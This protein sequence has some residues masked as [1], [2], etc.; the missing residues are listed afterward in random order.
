MLTMIRRIVS[1]VVVCALGVHGASRV[2]RPIHT[3]CAGTIDTVGES[4]LERIRRHHAVV[5]SDRAYALANMDRIASDAI[6]SEIRERLNNPIFVQHILDDLLRDPALVFER[7]LF[8]L[9]DRLF[10][11]NQNLY[12]RDAIDL[13]SYTF[14]SGVESSYIVR[15]KD[16]A[17]YG[18]R[19]QLIPRILPNRIGLEWGV[20]MRVDATKDHA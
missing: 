9:D 7:T 16:H 8:S 19:I 18:A 6:Q 2:V 13:H 17:M 20:M 12:W 10:A 5:A 11:E 4:P 15:D 14:K 1:R 3:T